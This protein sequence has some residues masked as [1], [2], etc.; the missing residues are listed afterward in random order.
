LGDRRLR[1]AG[2]FARDHNLSA[3]KDFPYGMGFPYAGQLYEE[4]AV[5]TGLRSGSCREIATVDLRR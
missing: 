2:E 1:L 5:L 3:R 4:P